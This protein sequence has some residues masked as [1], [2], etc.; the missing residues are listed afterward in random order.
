MEAMVWASIGVRGRG[1]P[2]PCA[3]LTNQ[4]K[5][6]PASVQREVLGVFV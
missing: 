1:V 2:A 6:S 5:R 4:M 3:W